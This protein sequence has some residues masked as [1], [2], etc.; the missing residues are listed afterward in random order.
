MLICLFSVVAALL[1][2]GAL[3][4]GGVWNY[5]IAGEWRPG[6]FPYYPAEGQSSIQRHWVDFKPIVDPTLPT[7]VCND[8]G[9]NAEE[10]ATVSAGS[11]IEAYLRGWPHDIGPIVV[12][13]AYC[14]EEPTSCSSFNGTGGKHW[15]KIGQAGLLSGDIRTGLWA[16]KHMIANNY[17]FGVTIPET[18]KGGAYLIRHEL[19]ALHVPFTPEFYPQCAHLWVASEGQDVPGEEFLAEIPGV[20][21][22]DEPELHLNIYQEPTASRTE[23]VI[24]GPPVWTGQDEGSN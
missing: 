24:P 14:G 4:H 22:D 5:S 1:P 20:W 21:K 19:V 17:T 23:W 8:P 11:E 13:M 16:Q 9:S 2:L 3:G 7:L 18:L 6:F 10:Y 15:F 12:W